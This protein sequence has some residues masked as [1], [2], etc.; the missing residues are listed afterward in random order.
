VFLFVIVPSYPGALY[1]LADDLADIFH[2]HPQEFVDFLLVDL[3]SFSLAHS[4]SHKEVGTVSMSIE[5]DPNAVIYLVNDT[6][7][8]FFLYFPCSAILR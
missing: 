7:S 4:S 1:K 6:D 8:C 2:L 5:V 3:D